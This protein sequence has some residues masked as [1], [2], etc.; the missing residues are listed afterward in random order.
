MAWRLNKAVVRGEI[1]N[2]IKGTVTG[3]IWLAGADDPIHLQLEGNCR[4]D[5]AGYLLTFENPKPEK[6]D[7]EHTGLNPVQNGLVGDMTASRKVWVLDIPIE[8][9]YRMNKRS[10]KPPE[11][12]A[13]YLYLEWYSDFNGRVVIES[14]DYR[15]SISEP[16]WLMTEEEEGAQCKAN[17]KAIVKW[18]ERLT[19]AVSAVQRREDIE[20]AEDKTWSSDDDAPMDEFQ[21][22]KFMKKSDARTDR[23]MKLY[24]KYDGVEPEELERLIARE[25]GWSH[26]EDDLDAKASA[27]LPETET[28]GSKLET[29]EFDMPEP[30]PLKEGIDWI[31]DEDDHPVH[32]LYL[33]TFET[34]TG[35]WH[36][37]DEAGLM[38]KNGNK[39][40]Q[41]MIFSAQMVNAKLA[42]ALNSLWMNHDLDGGFIVANLKRSLKFFNETMEHYRTVSA[43]GCIDPKRLNR[44]HDDLCAIRE[45]ILRLMD[46]YRGKSF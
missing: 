41:D 7:D 33:R 29:E 28:P 46:Q 10:G 34:V 6:T 42:G 14:T 1:D 35:M 12:M 18:M 24:E 45:E 17:G 13:N 30:D 16:S 40:V 2:R 3:R 5:M 19:G 26:V 20:A 11:H 23:M 9:A 21:W 43:D 15:I 39:A 8:E 22:E 38:R 37:C 31:R 4:R 25:M 44:F 32:P 36:D 27:E